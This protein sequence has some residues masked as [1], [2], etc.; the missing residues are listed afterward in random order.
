MPSYGNWEDKIRISKVSADVLCIQEKRRNEYWFCTNFGV[1]YHKLLK[2]MLKNLSLRSELDI[3]RPSNPCFSE[4]H[5]LLFVKGIKPNIVTSSSGTDLKLKQ[6]RA[7]RLAV[8]LRQRNPITLDRTSVDVVP[9]PN[10]RY[11]TCKLVIMGAAVSVG[12]LVVMSGLDGQRAW[13][14]GPEGPLVEEFWDNVRRYA[15]Y[16]LTVS[17]GAIYTIVQPI[18]ELLKN[19]ISAILV[20]A[21][22]A[23]SIFIVSQVLTAMV[24]VSDF[25]YNYAY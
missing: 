10:G 11:S 20:I 15:L 18:L 24:G 8:S 16:A 13:A 23:A 12:I 21:I 5:H 22:F 17:T 9:I 14:L 2:K 25:T 1:S 3:A 19:P 4:R 7:S 6:H